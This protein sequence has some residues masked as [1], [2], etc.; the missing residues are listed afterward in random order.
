MA[1]DMGKGQSGIENAHYDSAFANYRCV[2]D[3]ASAHAW[4]C[5][6]AGD[7]LA[8]LILEDATGF[9]DL[10]GF[11]AFVDLAALRGLTASRSIAGS[12]ASL[13]CRDSSTVGGAR[14]T[15]ADG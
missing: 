3:S 9:I 2:R 8:L 11:T 6:R 14:G 7:F 15:Q 13:L 5:R 1:E 10:A 12:I 4:G